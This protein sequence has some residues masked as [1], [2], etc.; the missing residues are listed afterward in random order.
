MS[1]SKQH[2]PKGKFQTGHSERSWLS[3]H[4]TGVLVGSLAMTAGVLG[5]ELHVA[6][7]KQQ[8]QYVDVITREPGYMSPSDRLTVQVPREGTVSERVQQLV[9]Q[10]AVDQ[11]AAQHLET[12]AFAQL[13]ENGRLP[14]KVDVF[15]DFVKPEVADEII[16]QQ[17][18]NQ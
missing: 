15:V 5:A 18:H 11:E 4:A 17:T 8:E 2:R 7:K 6:A 3:R 14:G 1:A 13:N 9:G 10:L 12:Q 16:D